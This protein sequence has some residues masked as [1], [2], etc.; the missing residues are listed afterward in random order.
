MGLWGVE[1][2]LAVVVTGGLH[3]VPVPLLRALLEEE[4]TGAAAAFRAA[5]QVQAKLESG[6][7]AAVQRAGAPLLQLLMT[8]AR[9]GDQL[10]WARTIAYTAVGALVGLDPSLVAEGPPVP[11]MARVHLTPQRPFLKE[12]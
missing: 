10:A 2:T 9:R 4:A 7:V 12:K 5:E 8:D 1:C 3:T 6:N 11:I